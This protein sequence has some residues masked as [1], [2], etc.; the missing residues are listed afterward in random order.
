M[1]LQNLSNIRTLVVKVGS[2]LVTAGGKGI[3]QA[4]LDRWAAQIAE[5]G[6]QG[7]QTVL[8]SSG[9]IAEGIK[10][11]GWSKR[12]T[13]INELQAA[14]AVGQTGIAQAYETAFAPHG[15]RTAQVLLTHDD[16][17]N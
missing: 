4:A 3:D 12:P 17:S 9:A 8:V 6:K 5:L 1:S 14:A 10:R 7:V 11:L 16:L 13:A 2:S 15:I